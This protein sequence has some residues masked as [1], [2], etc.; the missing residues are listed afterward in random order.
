MNEP[1][2]FTIYFAFK[3]VRTLDAEKV[4][5]EKSDESIV[6]AE[7]NKADTL[8]IRKPKKTRKKLVIKKE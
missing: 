4:K 7:L 1:F 8:K 2:P 3:K 6:E 5:L